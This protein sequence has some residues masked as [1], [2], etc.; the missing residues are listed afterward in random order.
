M[1]CG[2]YK[3]IAP[4]NR[5]YIGKSKDIDVRWLRYKQINES[6]Q[7]ELSGSIIKYGWD[8]HKF[9]I[10]EECGVDELH[11]LE[12]YYITYYKSCDRKIGMNMI[13]D[14]SYFM[15][16]YGIYNMNN[17]DYCLMHIVEYH[18]AVTKK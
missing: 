11:A 14:L 4:D 3:I 1:K 10:I 13:G 9:E 6:S 12:S 7:P 15:S 16:S 2:I 18:K 17:R 5:V 8:A